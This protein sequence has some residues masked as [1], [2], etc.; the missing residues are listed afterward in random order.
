M[1]GVYPSPVLGILSFPRFFASALHRAFIRRLFSGF[2]L[3]LVFCLCL[4]PG[5]YPSPVLRFR[6]FF[7]GRLAIGRCLKHVDPK[8][9]NVGALSDMALR[10]LFIKYTI[11]FAVKQPKTSVYTMFY[12]ILSDPARNFVVAF[13]RMQKTDFSNQF[14]SE[15]DVLC[16]KTGFLFRLWD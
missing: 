11:F 9:A 16:E 3:S 10:R 1:P 6:N 13:G 4:K 7:L 2:Y 15:I 8:N 12:D 14:D 5:V